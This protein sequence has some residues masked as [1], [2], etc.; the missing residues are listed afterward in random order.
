MF[1]DDGLVVWVVCVVDVFVLV[2]W[3]WGGFLFVL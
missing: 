2:G 3:F 1:V